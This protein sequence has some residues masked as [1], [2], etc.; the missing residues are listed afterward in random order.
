MPSKHSRQEDPSPQPM[1]TVVT[2]D[3]TVSLVSTSISCSDS[4]LNKKVEFRPLYAMQSP[5]APPVTRG[6][7]LKSAEFRRKSDTNIVTQQP[8][9]CSQKPRC[10]SDLDIVNQN[11]LNPRVVDQRRV[12]TIPRD[13]LARPRRS[14]G[15]VSQGTKSR[16]HVVIKQPSRCI[17]GPDSNPD[18]PTL[19]E[20]DYENC[21]DS[22]VILDEP[23]N[24][25]NSH[26]NASSVAEGVKG[27]M[28]L[29]YHP[30]QCCQ[31]K[32]SDSV[33]M[34]YNAREVIMC[35]F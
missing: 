35:K 24:H 9:F 1:A 6:S 15:N 32:V 3:G 18:W 29:L 23:G 13:S 8:S 19:N 4:A 28:K 2:K 10:K 22:T 30:F 16:D 26:Y 33:Q 11:Q 17:P 5:R 12:R 14:V 7:C 34:F 31:R 25:S 20:S 21:G 27:L